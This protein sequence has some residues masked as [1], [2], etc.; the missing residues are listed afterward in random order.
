MKTKIRILI[1]GASGLLGLNLALEAAKRYTVI[2]QTHRRQL[3]TDAF[4]VLQA[5]LTQADA[6]ER[7]LDQAEPDWV[8]NCAALANVD[9]CEASPHRASQ[10]NSELPGKLAA[11]VA[12][13]GARLLHVSTDAVFD[14]RRGNYSEADEPNPLSVYGRSKLDGEV[15]VAQANPDALIAR[16]NMYGWSL[17]GKRS[18]AEFFFYNLQS[19]N[20]VRGFT[21]VHFC[22]LLVNDLAGIFFKVF[23]ARLRGLYHVVSPDCVNKF[24]FGVAIARRF[25]FDESLITPT[26]VSA[27]GLK[28]VRAPKL[29]LRADKLIQA[30]GEAPPGLSTGLQRFYELYQQGYP[31]KLREMLP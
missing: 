8:I 29:T 6:A 18:L 7:L 3:Q 27:A 2:G 30:M 25:G 16:V 1:T 20:P 19:G 21:D 31:Q 13:G 23:E 4:R 17:S 28:A 14:G 11:Y 22:P 15:A 26:T 9:E 24:D 10:L 12:R 5:D